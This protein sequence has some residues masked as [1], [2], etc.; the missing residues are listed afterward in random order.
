MIRNPRTLLQAIMILV[1]PVLH[2]CKSSS[3]IVPNGLVA[4]YPFNGDAKDYSGNNLH[5]TAH[6]PSLVSDRH[7]R[8]NTAYSFDG[9]DYISVPHSELL[10]FGNNDNFSVSVWAWTNPTQVIGT[11]NDII[12]KWVGDAQG[13]PFT[14]SYINDAAQH[15]QRTIIAGRY[16]NAVCYDPSLITSSEI[17]LNV[18]H[19][20]VLVKEGPTLKL[21]IDNQL[22][23][24]TE[25]APECSTKNTAHMTIGS[26]GQLSSFFAGKIDDVRIYNR[27]L[28][29]EEITILFKE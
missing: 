26:R 22:S 8:K 4:Y 28:T 6:G 5:G 12:R 10:N 25:D 2:G 16:N 17:T 27:A 3:I 14:I 13:Y 7:D 19:H 24:T 1:L 20:I 23:G 15:S 18:F 11:I 21:F 9:D 29:V